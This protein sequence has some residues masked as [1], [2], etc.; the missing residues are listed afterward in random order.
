MKI[1]TVHNKYKFRGGEDECRE[2]DAQLMAANGHDIRDVIFE[3]DTITSLNAVSVGLQSIWNSSSYKRL[4]DEIGKWRPDVV[5]V[6]NFFPVASPSVYY[7]ARRHGVPVVQTLHNYRLL[8]PGALFFRD[9]H[10]CEDCMGKRMPWP[11]V[12]H[13]CYRSSRGA[14]LAVASMLT[15]HNLLGTW[16]KQVDMFIALTEFSKR[17]FIEGGLPAER[18]TI[19]PNFLTA[20]PGAG[21]GDGDFV[22]YV[23]RLTVDKGLPTLIEAWKAAACAGRLIIAG[24]GPLAPFVMKEASLCDSIS[25]LG[26]IP[27]AQVFDL[28]A[29][30][31]AL[32]FP[33]T[34]YEG[35]PRVIVESFSRGTPIIASAIGSMPEMIVNGRSGWLV[36]PGDV[37]SL[38]AAMRTVFSIREEMKEIRAAARLEFEHKYTP[39]RNYFLLAEIFGRVIAAKKPV[40]EQ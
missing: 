5:S 38:A 7:A 10:V 14:T 27:L 23:G 12:L 30:A 21:T 19:K 36:A 9:G 17:K 8:C 33:S 2:A 1:L 26:K 4:S 34:W 22:I 25:Y 39:E 16:Q 37:Q 40:A 18:V 11:G 20:D 24:D 3:N 29:S 32:V 15:V 31:R 6:H 28:L 35:M 13:G